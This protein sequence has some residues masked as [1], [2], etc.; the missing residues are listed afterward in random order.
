MS[1]SNIIDFEASGRKIRYNKLNKTSPMYSPGIKANRIPGIVK[2]VD[3]VC[4]MPD[5][6]PQ[7]CV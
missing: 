4:D 6:R 5:T 1:R 7:G 2:I 3:F